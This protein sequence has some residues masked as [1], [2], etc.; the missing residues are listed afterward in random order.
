MAKVKNTTPITLEP[1]QNRFLTVS[2]TAEVLQLS[3]A[4]VARL[5]KSGDLPH[6]RIGKTVRVTSDALK[7]LGTSR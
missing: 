1:L 6:V 7:T 3:Q 5:I 4:T 2:Q